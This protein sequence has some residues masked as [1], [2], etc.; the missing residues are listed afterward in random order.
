MKISNLRSVLSFLLATLG[1]G[2]SFALLG[3]ILGGSH[4]LL[5]V[6]LLWSGLLLG[7]RI[8]GRRSLLGFLFSGGFLSLHLVLGV[9]FLLIIA[10]LFIVLE[11]E[12][13]DTVTSDEVDGS[14][15]VEELHLGIAGDQQVD[16]LLEV[17]A[18][19]H[20]TDGNGNLQERMK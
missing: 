17:L 6:S 4:L 14:L 5:C 15:S 3:V 11:A 9:P 8:L 10:V 7:G 1:L 20:G 12:V 18:P 13:V 2:A 16:V 19:L